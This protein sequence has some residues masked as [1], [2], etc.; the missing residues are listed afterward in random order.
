MSHKVL[1]SVVGPT[2]IGKTKFSIALAKYFRTEIIS[3]DSRQFFKELNIGTAVPSITELKEIPHHFIQHKSIHEPYS[4]G[5][6]ER[7][8]LDRLRELF[9]SYEV[10][11]M[12]G[13]SGLYVNA[14]CKGLDAFPDVV[15]KTRDQ[16]NNSYEEEGIEALQR[17]LRQLDPE[18]YEQV[19]LNNPHRLIRALEVCIS[20][21][22]PYSSFLKKEKP[23]RPF[24]VLTVGLHAA[25]EVVYDRINKRVDKMMEQGL[26]E[27]VRALVPYK[28]LNA[29]QSVGYNELFKY[30]DGSWELDFA[31][32]E[33]KKNTR[34]FAKRQLTWFNKEQEI[35][36]INYE[37][38]M[39]NVIPKIE[40][41][42]EVLRNER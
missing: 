9:N 26:L 42:L 15:P 13:G 25:R 1:I 22:L 2:A 17:Q 10:V 3:A 18:Y 27:E 33:I 19:D 8:V 16:L 38:A 41:N 36:W 14:V 21:G 34:R 35:L 4:V 24:K 11:I 6:F 12:T 37:E 31:V 30:L 7:D 40:T 20:A 28:D 39:A 29:L 5:D 23:P 32:S